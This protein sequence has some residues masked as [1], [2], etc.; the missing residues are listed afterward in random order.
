MSVAKKAAKKAG[1]HLMGAAVLWGTLAMVGGSPF[2][3]LRESI[4]NA[5]NAQVQAPNIGNPT[6]P[7]TVE[8]SNRPNPLDQ[9]FQIG[10]LQ[11]DYTGSLCVG[12]HQ[13][14]SRIDPETGRI[15]AEVPVPNRYIDA[16]SQD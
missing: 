4:L 8:R 6:R 13:G 12:S 7:L 14:L 10:A 11:D 5:V 1:Q 2:K 16:M 15:L 3:A 9:D